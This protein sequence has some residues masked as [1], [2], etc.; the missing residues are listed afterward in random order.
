MAWK[1]ELPGPS[2]GSPIAV[3]GRV[4]VTA[5]PDLLIAVDAEDGEILWQQSHGWRDVF[6]DER[7]EEIEQNLRAAAELEQ[8]IQPLR[9]ELD[10]LRKAEPPD[11]DAIARLEERIKTLE[12]EHKGLTAYPPPSSGGARNTTPTPVSD[13]ARVFVAFGNGIAAAYNFDGER[14]WTT[15]VHEPGGGADHSASPLIVNGRLVVH[16]GALVALDLLSG[17]EM[18]RT[19][20]QAS[21]GSPVAV[22]A[23]DETMIVTGAGAVIRAA[24]GRLVA[25]KLF[26]TGWASP[27]PAEGGVVGER[28]GR[29]I[30]IRLPDA[31]HEP[32]TADVEWQG[33]EMKQRRLASV[34]VHDALAYSVNE[35]GVLDVIDAQTGELV[36]RKRLG[37]G[38]GRVDPS[39]ALAGGRLYASNNAGTTIVF[40]PGREYAEVA[41]NELEGFTSSPVFEG[42]RVYVRTNKRLYAIGEAGK[43]E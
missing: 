5:E 19:E 25:E 21:H 29:L 32:A 43:P 36:Y 40:E 42:N 1:T 30:A 8:R 34:V 3:A 11:E 14:L 16:H 27:V 38:K 2:H 39:L 37:F 9:K 7:G 20:T 13:G 18:W 28:D 15:H 22:N 17:A 41:R 26:N 33:P 35:I 4:F 12:A 6:P 24:D 23:G 31:N 10:A